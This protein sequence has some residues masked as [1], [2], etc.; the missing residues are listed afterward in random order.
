MDIVC[1]KCGVKKY[2]KNGF[3]RGVQRY[4][5]KQCGCNFIQKDS[6][7]KVTLEGKALAVLLYA[8]GKSSYGFIARLF[9]V[10]RTAVLKW[11]RE[12]SRQI[13]E[14]SLTSEIKEIEFDEM[15]HFLNLNKTKYGYGKPWTV[16]QVE[17]SLGLLAIVM[18]KRFESST[19][20]SNT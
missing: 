18:L 19:K 4:R 13:P 17:P 6:R 9:N 3:V 12:F 1:K 8:S 2:T 14:P 20:K 7:Q 16:L 11:I 5:C 15:W 10:S